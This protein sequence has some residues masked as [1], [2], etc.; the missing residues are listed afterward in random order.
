MLLTALFCV[1]PTA[2]YDILVRQFQYIKLRLLDQTALVVLCDA[3][4]LKLS[5]VTC[6][7]LGKEY[8]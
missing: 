8:L 3:I 7:T 1:G 4:T 2:G 5:H 6:A